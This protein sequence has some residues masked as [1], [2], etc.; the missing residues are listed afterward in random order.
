MRRPAATQTHRA[1]GSLEDLYRELAPAVL[2]YLPGWG[3]SD[4][5]DVLGNVFSP[6]LRGLPS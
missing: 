4:P 6:V 2:G 3:A 5:E 1:S